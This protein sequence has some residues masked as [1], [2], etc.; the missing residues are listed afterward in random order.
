[1]TR[2]TM[3]FFAVVLAVP[4]WA[5]ACDDMATYLNSDGSLRHEIVLKEERG[6]IAGS[7]ETTLKIEPSGIWTRDAYTVYVDENGVKST[8]GHESQSGKLGNDELLEIARVLAAE[9]FHDLPAA[10]GR[11]S[12]VNATK[13]TLTFG[14]LKATVNGGPGSI[15]N[16]DPAKAVIER[17]E[18]CVSKIQA[19]LRS[20]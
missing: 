7:R 13:K 1:M 18:T 14:K 10:A 19:T 12:K 3:T 11:P 5:F 8:F 2:F 17:F 20:K 16:G 15:D 6:S 9:Q 4:V